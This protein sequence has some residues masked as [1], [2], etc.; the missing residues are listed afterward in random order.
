MTNETPSTEP[1][2]QAAAPNESAPNE[3]APQASAPRKAAQPKS[4]ASQSETTE[5]MKVTRREFLN[6]AWMASLGFMTLSIG[7]M[8]YFFAIPRFKEG[9]FG[10]DFPAGTVS[11]LPD[12]SGGPGNF[13]SGKFWLSNTEEGVT[14]L[15]KVCTHLGCLYAWRDQEGKF[16]CPCHGS[17]FERDGSYIKGPAPRSLDSFAMRAVDPASGNVLAQSPE[18]GGPMPIPEDPNAV[19]IV[20]TGK[21]NKGEPK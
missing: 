14:A 15:Y 21:R 16:V 8:A 7:G 5:S 11:E 1:D 13:P 19:I 6:V 3:S 12:T 20:D 4:T 17:E 10:G 2:P 18:G 9:E